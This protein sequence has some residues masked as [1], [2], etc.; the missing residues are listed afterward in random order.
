MDGETDRS[1]E[2]S[3]GSHL[4]RLTRL[5][6]GSERPRVRESESGRRGRESGN[7][8]TDGASGATEIAARLWGAMA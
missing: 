1:T 6:A 5:S 2:Y 3:S 7:K 8:R 4:T